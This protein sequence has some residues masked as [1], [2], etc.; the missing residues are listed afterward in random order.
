[1]SILSLAVLALGGFVGG[2][3]GS[4]VGSA[5]LISLPL[6]I[7]LGFSPHMAVATSRPAAVVLELVSALRYAYEGKLSRTEL[8]MGMLL[9]IFGAIGGTIGAF[10]ISAVSD[11]ALRILFAIVISSMFL[12]LTLRKGWGM[13]E[14]PERK[15]HIFVLAMTTL[16]LGVY[17]GFFGFTF[18]TLMTVAL[19]LFGFTLLQGA[20]LSRVIGI[21]TSLAATVVFVLQGAA[22]LAVGYAVGGWVGAGVGSKK[23]SP[24]VKK[25]LVIVVVASVHKLLFDYFSA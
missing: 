8:K 14:R 9:G 25:I 16:A 15:K 18:G 10:V 21:L 19:T 5:G 20:V 22:A 2:F 3:F 11:Q 23:G 17:G 24:Y 1:M 12:F 7:L 13:T 4:A 6:L